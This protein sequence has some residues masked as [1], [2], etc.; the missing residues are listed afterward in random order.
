MTPVMKTASIGCGAYFSSST[1]KKI[2][3][4]LSG[5]A[6]FGFIMGHL[7]GNLQIFEGQEAIN[8]YAVFLRGLGE[9]L[10]V[11]RIGLVGMVMVHIGTSI[12]L[13]I[14]NKAAR[15]IG[16]ARKDYV[17]AGLTSRTMILSGLAAL[18]FIVYHLLHFTFLKVHPQYARLID[19]QGRP[20]VY[21]MM[22]LSFRQPG[23]SIA[24][25]VGLFLLRGHLSHGIQSMFQSLGLSNGKFRDGLSLWG[26]RLAWLIFAGYASIPASVWLGIVKLPLGVSLP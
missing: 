10:W 17:K 5:A 24:Y 2:L 14:E 8:R 23:I 9:L 19:T 11:A 22:V 26:G 21:S 13:T 12:A 20:D 6:L 4:A 7:A 15:P 18:A 1:G 16:Y 3:M 25:I